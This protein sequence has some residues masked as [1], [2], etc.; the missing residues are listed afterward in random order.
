MAEKKLKLSL[1][2]KS[3]A[4]VHIRK[5]LFGA[6]D[7]TQSSNTLSTNS[8]KE[9]NESATGPLEEIWGESN[10]YAFTQPTS[11]SLLL[12]PALKRTPNRFSTSPSPKKS[13]ATPKRGNSTP[14]KLSKYSPFR[15]KVYNP[16]P[17]DS[18]KRFFA[19]KEK[20]DKEEDTKS[21]FGIEKLNDV[22]PSTSACALNG[23]IPESQFSPSQTLPNN[24]AIKKLPDLST[25]S[26]TDQ[27]TTPAKS[28][29]STPKSVSKKLSPDSKITGT[30]DVYASFLLR[31]L[32]NAMFIEM[33]PNSSLLSDEEHFYVTTF[34][35]LD[36]PAQR[37]YG[38][39]LNRKLDWIRTSSMKYG[40]VDL[41][42][43][44]LEQNGFITTG[45]LFAETVL[46]FVNFGFYLQ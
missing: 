17:K 46:T 5:D 18:I 15:K 31:V 39:L 23:N 35:Q 2:S 42:L 25:P 24:D 21:S 38:R 33:D 41:Q 37:L 27:K 7:S 1:S 26:K 3:S 36:Q 29:S 19:V 10:N 45:M 44:L 12:S 13:P 9:T 40:D 20:H 28:T 34:N 14:R 8:S 11:N 30:K 22:L 6:H 16:D 43:M 4:K 32:M